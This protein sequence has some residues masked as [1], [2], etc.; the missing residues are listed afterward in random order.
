MRFSMTHLF[1]NTE[2]E[3]FTEDTVPDWLS[4][5]NTVKG[6]TMDGRWWWQD[7][8][9]KLNVGESIRSDFREITR[10]E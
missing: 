10:L 3:I 4:S 5:C 2:P 7:H 9:M 8:V 1:F 6:S